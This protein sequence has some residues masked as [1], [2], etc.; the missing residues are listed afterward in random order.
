MP[1][2]NKVLRSMNDPG[3]AR[4]VD[5]YRRP[6]GTIGFEEFR[7]DVEDG[8]GWFP[9]GGHSNRVFT[10]KPRRWQPPWP[11]S[12]GSDPRS[13]ALNAVWTP[14]SAPYFAWSVSE[15]SRKASREGGDVG[16][17]CKAS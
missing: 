11:Q 2:V 7:R 6:D 15:S 5:I 1:H 17:C 16:D 12:P 13:A 10:V 3:A 8:R 9:I 14:L 4:C